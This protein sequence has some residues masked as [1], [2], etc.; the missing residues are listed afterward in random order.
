MNRTP[1]ELQR[2]ASETPSGVLAQVIAPNYTGSD[3]FWCPACQGRLRKKVMKG[4]DVFGSPTFGRYLDT[5]R[6]GPS[7]G[8]VDALRWRCFDCP[9][10]GLRFELERLILRDPNLT[11][12]LVAV[13]TEHSRAA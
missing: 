13:T 11:K 4:G 7:A 6:N 5:I 2:L 8:F 10:D 9:A 1:R 12:V 3:R